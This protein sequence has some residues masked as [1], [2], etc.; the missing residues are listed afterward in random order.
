M[1][2]KNNYTEW[3]WLFFGFE[4]RVEVS[5]ESEFKKSTGHLFDLFFQFLFL[6]GRVSF[7]KNR[8]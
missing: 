5:K 2:T 4:F 3:N 6:G 7:Y 8:K 1:M